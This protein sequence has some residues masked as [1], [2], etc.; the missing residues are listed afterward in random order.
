M[1]RIG[2]VDRRMNPEVE[3]GL[4][5]D[6][7]E[8]EPLR[9]K[10]VYWNFLPP[11]ELNELLTLYSRVTH[12]TLRISK[13]LGIEYGKLL[14]PEDDYDILREFNTRY[15]G[16]MSPVERLHL[17]YQKLLADHPGL[18]SRLNGLPLRVF[19]GR[20]RPPA[21]ATG[22]FFCYSVPGPDMSAATAGE[23]PE[24]AEAAGMTYWYFYHLADGQI[25]SEPP[26]ISDLIRSKPDTPRR[27][28]MD[29]LALHDVR[30]QIEKHIKDTVLKRLQAPLD[31]KPVLKAWMELN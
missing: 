27:C 26:A 10:I 23:P 31:V 22:V 19:S 8:L 29:R 21:T 4:L 16:Q 24:W 7:P 18:E 3:A 15:E 11:A 14:R 6:H 5:A 13:T 20:E 28:T 30:K 25:V 12:K 17:E 2:R 9:G 1:Q